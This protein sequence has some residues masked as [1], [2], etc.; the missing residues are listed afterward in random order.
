MRL[1]GLSI[2]WDKSDN[3]PVPERLP[4]GFIAD[5]TQGLLKVSP[6]RRESLLDD[7]NAITNAKCVR[8]QARKIASLV[9][10]IISMKLAWGPITQIY[11][12]NLYHIPNS[13]A[14]LNY[15]ATFND[16]ALNELFFWKDLPRLRFESD[17]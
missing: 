9:G 8:V 14:S 13:I 7:T 10:A 16:E 1:A 11:T 17:I 4:L 15:W 2:N 3:E 5:L 12:R 6:T